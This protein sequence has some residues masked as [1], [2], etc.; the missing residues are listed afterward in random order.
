MENQN[1][2]QISESVILSDI[3]R[4]ELSAVEGGFGGGFNMGWGG[5]TGGKYDGTSWE[6]DMDGMCYIDGHYY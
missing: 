3:E 1:R 6:T 5:A 2:T 4:T